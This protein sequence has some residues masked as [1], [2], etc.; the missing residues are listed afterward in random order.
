[1]R[2]Q[3]VE[4][5]SWDNEDVFSGML[6]RVAWQKL[7]DASDM[8]TASIIRATIEA[9]STPKYL[10]ISVG[11]HGVP[12]QKTKIFII[13]EISPTEAFPASSSGLRLRV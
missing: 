8:L 3:T 11:L 4:I 2:L 10:S 9:V 13:S 6:R 5:S 1:M 7:T 12:S